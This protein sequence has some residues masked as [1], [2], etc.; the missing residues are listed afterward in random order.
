MASEF[1]TDNGDIVV[2]RS[3]FVLGGH[4]RVEF[5]VDG[6]VLFCAPRYEIV[7]AVDETKDYGRVG[8]MR[9]RAP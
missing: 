7:R 5:V 6:K 3:V 9:K 4:P 8:E 1:R 2:V